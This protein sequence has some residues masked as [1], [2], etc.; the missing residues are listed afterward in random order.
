[1]TPDSCLHKAEAIGRVMMRK[2]A[3]I[4]KNKTHNRQWKTRP[5][6]VCAYSIIPCIL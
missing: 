4:R 6:S 1:M 2:V 3:S 5:I